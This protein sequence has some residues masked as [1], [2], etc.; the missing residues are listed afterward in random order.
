MGLP[1][2]IQLNSTRADACS[3]CDITTDSTVGRPVIGGTGMH[4]WFLLDP[5][6][7]GTACRIMVEQGWS[8]VMWMLLVPSQDHRWW[9]F[10]KGTD[11]YGFHQVPEWVP[12]GPCTCPGRT[13]MGPW[14]GPWAG[15]NA[16]GTL[17][18][19]GWSQV[20]GLL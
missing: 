10:Y 11:R 17:V 1:P 12:I 19:W 7:N 20:I 6:V 15:T 3:C 16:S 8:Q 14:T 13:L 9:A 5:L 2:Q 18:E 4:T